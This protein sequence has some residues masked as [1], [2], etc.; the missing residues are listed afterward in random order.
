MVPA[1]CGAGCV[2]F[3]GSGPGGSGGLS[4]QVF[5]EQSG[6][7]LLVTLLN[8]SQTQVQV[9]TDVLTGVY[10]TLMHNTSVV[11]LTPL[12]AYIA[13]QTDPGRLVNSD[14]STFN[15]GAFTD[16][17]GINVG[18]EF[19]YAS[20]SGGTTFHGA[21]SGISSSGLGLFGDGNFCAAG[22]ANIA[23]PVA[24]DGAQ[25]GI[26]PLVGFLNPNGGVSGNSPYVQ[27]AVQF[28]LAG[29]P[30]GFNLT[31]GSLTGVGFQ[32][33]TSLS[34]PSFNAP[35]PATLALLGLGGMLGLL[36]LRRRPEA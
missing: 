35:A 14:G 23:G 20:F 22:C 26:V 1:T 2:Q 33:G 25:V 11:T 13:D 29:L 28:K 6:S 21:Q 8:T 17:N 31:S 12:T 32:Y 30:A 9:P 10:F 34:E 7:D 16:A 27:S 5:F 4:A 15:A 19:G 3:S 36:V 24:L 18:G